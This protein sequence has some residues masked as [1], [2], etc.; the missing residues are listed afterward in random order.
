MIAK[1]I[2][3]YLPLYALI[4]IGLYIGL[5]LASHGKLVNNI[6]L[7]LLVLGSLP[8]LWGIVVEIYHRQFGVDIIA[9]VAIVAAL[10]LGQYLTGVVI[11]LMLSGGEALEAYAFRRAKKELT[12]LLARAPVVAHL[13]K[14]NKVID[15]KIEQIQPGDILVVKPG[16]VIPTDGNVVF[17]QS[18]VDESAITGESLPVR[19]GVASQVLSGTVNTSEVL[20]IRVA[21]QSKDSKYEQLI[22]LVRQAEQ[23]KAP[24]VRLADRYTVVFTIITFAFA[25]VAWLL[26]GDPVRVLAVLVVATP[27]PLILATPIAIISGINKSAKRGI[28]VKDGGV[29]EQL[30]EAKAFVFD[31]TGTITLGSPKVTSIKAFGQ[32]ENEILVLAASLDQLSTH[33]LARSLLDYAREQH[34]ELRYPSNYAEVFGEGVSGSLD[35]KYFFGRLS[36]I[37]KHGVV[38]PGGVKDEHNKQQISGIIAVYLSDEKNLLGAIYFADVIRPE[39]ASV[40]EKIRE[41]GVKKILMLTGDRTEIAKKISRQIGLAEVYAEYMP[42]QKLGMVQKLRSEGWKPLVMVGDGVN[43]AAALTAA[44]VGIAM[45][46]H[47]SSASSEASGIV[48]AVDDLQKVEQAYAIAKRTLRIALQGIFVGMGLSI[49]L[50]VLASLGFIQP[51]FGAVMQEAIDVIVIFNALRVLL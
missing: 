25:L 14:D 20:E 35:K 38:I 39:S 27:C 44:D 21:K 31:K 15:V 6:T 12:E 34:L 33:I 18:M 30:G 47:G 1:T 9:I 37:E 16:E 41:A 8:L 7:V 32:S 24:I 48:I 49:G 5:S 19:A 51:V 28:I 10:I 45:G 2:K 42:E 26:S 13:K 43:D 36:F 4:V 17:G 3:K 40:F 46:A 22:R 11:L 23:V 29:L 50:M